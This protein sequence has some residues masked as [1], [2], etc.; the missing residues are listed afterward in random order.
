MVAASS[1]ASLAT[2]AKSTAPGPK[3]KST[4]R[5]VMT[6]ASRVVT[7]VISA[8]LSVRTTQPVYGRI[9]ARTRRTVLVSVFLLIAFAPPPPG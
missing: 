4:A 1:T 7:T 9:S 5:P 6:G 3:I 2:P 8:R